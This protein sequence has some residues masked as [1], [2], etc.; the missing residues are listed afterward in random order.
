MKLS[1]QLFSSFLLTALGILLVFFVFYH[2]GAGNF[3]DYLRQVE[4][5]KARFLIADL[6]AEYAIR[7]GWEAIKREPRLWRELLNKH[8]F[9]IP[10]DPKHR[11]QHAK[12]RPPYSI[13]PPPNDKDRPDGQHVGPSRARDKDQPGFPEYLPGSTL[14]GPEDPFDLGPRLAIY[15]AQYGY[16]AGDRTPIDKMSL[17]A[18]EVH[19]RLA[20]WLGIK[21]R[22]QVMTTL[23]AAFL[24]RQYW[25]IAIVG[26]VTLVLISLASWI[27]AR[28]VVRPVKMLSEA[29]RALAQRRYNVGIP[30]H[31]QD[32]LGQLARDF[33]DMARNIEQYE[34]KRRQW[35]G[36]IAHELRTPL[37]I[38][39]GEIEAILDGIRDVTPEALNSLLTEVTRLHKLVENLHQLTIAESDTFAMSRKPIDLLTILNDTLNLFQNRLRE[40]G[41]GLTANNIDNQEVVIRGDRDRLHQLFSNIL[42]NTLKYCSNGKLWVWAVVSPPHV[43]IH[44]QDNGPGVPEDS[45]DRLF[46]RL[47]RVD[48][49]RSR[50][51]GGSGLGLAICKQ[52]VQAHEGNIRAANA[53]TGGLI[54]TVLFPLYQRRSD[55]ALGGK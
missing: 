3:A 14:S 5:E 31:S 2:I 8:G 51:T 12:P 53:P 27:V 18:I 52:I 22:K 9:D 16:V 54:V 7:G 38:L 32:E 39:R 1:Y 43:V 26:G 46:D 41:I 33:S 30:I 13:P 25:F 29:T 50:K 35:V 15:D 44:F 47:Y 21:A 40:K 45:L 48:P 42:E 19:G 4:F 24:R 6:K 36:D 37:T 11:P 20:G 28:Q 17:R 10:P 55:K 49:S 34:T 23:E